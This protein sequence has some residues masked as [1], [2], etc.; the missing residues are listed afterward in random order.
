MKLRVPRPSGRFVAIA[1]AT[2]PVALA[3]GVYGF[4]R[5][6]AGP[7]AVVRRGT[8]AIRLA[9]AG[10]LRPREA[11]T[12]RSPLGT[13]DVEVTS[14]APEGARVQEGD[15]VVRL[16]TS[17]LDLDRLRARQALRQAEADLQG[18]EADYEDASAGLESLQ[19]GEKSLDVDESRANVVLAEKKLDR[20]R[21]EYEGLRPLLE[22][23]FVTRDEL[24]R[25][26]GELEQAQL[27]LD[28]TR[29]KSA[30]LVEKSRPRDERRA[31]LLV[32]QRSA[33]IAQCR[34]RLAE[35]TELVHAFDQAREACTMRARGPGLVLYEYSM[36]AAPRRKVRVGDRVTASQGLITISDV[37]RMTV[38]S[39]VREAD[40][41]LLRPGQP[42][43]IA[44]DAA[45]GLKLTGRVG[46][47]GVLAYAPVDRPYDEKRYD[48]T[49][50]VDPSR[51]D[52]QPEMTA[53]VEM[54]VAERPN[55][56]LLPVAAILE[57]DGHPSVVPARGW[58][59]SPVPVA[60][61]R[62]DGY[63]VEI[64]G[65][66]AKGTRVRLLPATSPAANLAVTEA[67]GLAG[68]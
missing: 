63:L 68:K 30:M 40:V 60:L 57:T 48:V 61:G 44:L 4:F 20:L 19:S 23:G 67:A 31:R 37:A 49:I 58:R 25:A 47:V 14:L 8:L 32:G 53:R 17:E 64:L 36:S 54:L 24:D 9:E 45:P 42:T 16:D 35:A 2:V 29:R 46:R 56:L 65:G 52:L 21:R 10:V 50:D 38:E 1:L 66:L 3:A 13:R 55:A 11:A 33:R 59:R 62:T 41:H 18:A 34:E 43:T 15:L 26:A 39:S 7:E 27:A 51:A 22:K 12:Y 5:P 6:S 28:I